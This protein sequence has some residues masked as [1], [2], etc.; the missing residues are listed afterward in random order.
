MARIFLAFGLLVPCG[1][2]GQAPVYPPTVFTVA[3]IK[4]NKSS[5]SRFMLLPLPGG[6]LTATGV[7]LNMLVMFAYSVAA[8]QISGAPSWM[9]TERWD[10]QA[11]T[12][13]VQGRLPPN[14]F[15]VLL[16][17]LIEDRF[18]LK[19]RRKTKNLPVYALVMAKGGPKL[20]PHPGGTGERKPLVQF[21]NGSAVF[22]DSSVA[23]LAGQLT[24]NLGRPVI[25][26]T[27]IK[28]SYDFA[29]D[30]T[31]APD[32]GGAETIGLPPRAEPPSAGESNG[33]SIFTALQDQLGLKL[34][35][36][37]GPVDILVIDHVERPSEN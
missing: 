19:A 35:S 18:Q 5:D 6:G 8:Y 13:G 9:G 11:K 32:E 24:L 36:Q 20:K 28:G 3:S 31:P 12:D 29:L 37:K 17:G 15:S 27:G 1:L 23:G 14:Q 26:R 16:R 25:D 34:K 22:S 33:P 30:W 21:G 10:I 4:P 7:T 2:F